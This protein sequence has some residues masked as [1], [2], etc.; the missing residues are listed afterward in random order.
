MLDRRIASEGKFIDEEFK[1]ITLYFIAP[2]EMLNGK[3]EADVTTISVEFSTATP[4]PYFARVM[5]SPAIYDEEDEAYEDYVWFDVEIS[6]SEISELMALGG[7]E[8]DKV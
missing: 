3:F 4:E 5:Y 8:Y 7:F 2:E 6:D 1:T